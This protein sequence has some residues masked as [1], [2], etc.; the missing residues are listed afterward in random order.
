MVLGMPQ[1]FQIGGRA[2][3]PLDRDVWRHIHFQLRIL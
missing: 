2:I 1:D 3:N